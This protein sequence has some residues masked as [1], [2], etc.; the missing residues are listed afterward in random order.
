MAFNNYKTDSLEFPQI[1]LGH[2]KKVLELSSSELRVAERIIVLQ[3]SR[4]IVEEEDTRKSF[5]QAVE[6]LSYSL[7][8]YFD[9]PMQTYFDDAIDYLQGFHSEIIAKLP[10]GD[11]K[12]VLLTQDK[13]SKRNSIISWQVKT[14]KKLYIEL[15]KLL[16]R[17]DFLKGA[18]Y[19]EGE[20]LELEGA[21]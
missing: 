12:K 18:I 7:I 4:E 19:G 14:A 10:E 8:P 3:N 11:F 21:S 6:M 5:C 16:K 15:V 1:I 13:E 17:Q 20:E 9:E 2:I